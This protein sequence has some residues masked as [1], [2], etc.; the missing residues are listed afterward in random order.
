[1]PQGER[2][3]HSRQ[4]TH[5]GSSA[6]VQRYGDAHAFA[7]TFNPDLQAA[8]GANV[9]RSF[10]G[11]APAISSLVAAYGAKAVRV[12]VYAQLENLNVFVGAKNKIEP[13]QMSMLADIIITDYFYLKASELLLFFHQLKSGRYGKFYGSVDPMQVSVA[14]TEFAAYRRDMIFRLENEKRISESLDRA[15]KREALAITRGQYLRRK[16]TKRKKKIK[17]KR[18][19]DSK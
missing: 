16:F 18:K 7:L 11:T 19:D 14:L 2:G 9:E 13:S 1:M 3:S 6:I 15:E 5:S 12:W 4:L 10:T 8:C 17:I